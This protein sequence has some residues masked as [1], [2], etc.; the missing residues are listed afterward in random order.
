VSPFFLKWRELQVDSSEIYSVFRSIHSV[1]GGFRLF[2]YSNITDL[3]HSIESNFSQIREGELELSYE[4]VDRLIQCMDKVNVMVNDPIHSSEISIDKEISL[5]LPY[6]DE[7]SKR[8][9]QI[10]TSGLTEISIPS[11]EEVAEPQNVQAIVSSLVGQI[12][13]TKVELL[14]SAFSE[15]IHDLEPFL[16]PTFHLYIINGSDPST[17]TE[18]YMNSLLEDN[19]VFQGFTPKAKNVPVLA[20]VVEPF[21]GFDN[22]VLMMSSVLDPDMISIALEVGDSLVYEVQM[23][24][25]LSVIEEAAEESIE[26]VSE[27]EIK[28]ELTTEDLALAIKEADPEIVKNIQ[29]EESSK[30]KPQASEKATPASIESVRKEATADES[31]R[32]KVELLNDLMNSAGE[33]I[34]NRN[35]LLQTFNQNKSEFIAIDEIYQ[36][37]ERLEVNLEKS[38]T[39]GLSKGQISD[40]KIDEILTNEFQ[41]N[42]KKVEEVLNKPLNTNATIS[43][44]T[45][46]LDRNTSMLQESIMSTRMQ[47]IMNLFN[48]FPRIIRDLSMSLEKEVDLDILGRNVELAKTILEKLA[49]PMV[50]LI[51]NSMDHGIELPEIRLKNNKERKGKVELS[52]FHEGGKV[53]ITIQD[54]GGGIRKD[55]VLEIAINKGI[56]KEDQKDLMSDKEIHHLIFAPGFSTID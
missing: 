50:H 56:V 48:K 38:L 42:F 23:D 51:R 34:L 8:E 3:T 31:L 14:K 46:S 11:E 45:Q 19:N 7:E 17:S 5:L 55:K 26:E 2:G 20:S 37:I 28:T 27:I 4:L 43:S 52:A 18:D 36:E 33:L 49:D 41:R 47:P 35:Q 1:K 13:K 9:L 15:D 10:D 24:D 54:D 16:R 32:V 40:S 29:I 12:T 53:I 39:E 6:L 25:Q 44:L 30:P 21:L 22:H